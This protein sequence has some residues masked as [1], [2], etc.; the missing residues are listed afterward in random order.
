MYQSSGTLEYNAMTSYYQTIQST[1]A[2]INFRLG[3]SRVLGCFMNFIPST[4]LNN[5]TYDG[6]ATLPLIDD[7]SEDVPVLRSTQEG[8]VEYVKH[9]NTLF[10]K[11]LDRG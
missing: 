4:Y 9:N 2:I 5:L 1:N 7:L 10:K 3:L 11:V 6:F 8:L